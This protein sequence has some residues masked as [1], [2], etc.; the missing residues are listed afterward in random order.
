MSRWR[1]QRTVR[2]KDWVLWWRPMLERY[3]W[4]KFPQKYYSNCSTYKSSSWNLSTM[5]TYVPSTSG[6]SEIAACPP[7]PITDGPSA[8]PS[9]H[10]STL[11]PTLPPAVSN[12]S[13]LFTQCQP[14]S[15]S[16]GTVLLYYSK[17]CKIKNVFFILC[18]CFYVLFVWKVLLYIYIDLLQ[19]S[20]I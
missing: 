16:C 4:E 10:P 18:V 1:F 3:V 6:V 11:P 8:L 13:C 7:S 5:W 9:A 2:N 12:S 20:S 15:V 14:L 17:Y 19:F